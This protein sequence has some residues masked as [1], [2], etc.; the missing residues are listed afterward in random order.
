[1]TLAVCGLAIRSEVPLP[2]VP[3]TTDVPDVIIRL[4]RVEK[5]PG[6]RDA[7]R[8]YA[9]SSEEFRVFWRGVGTFSIRRGCEVIIDPDADTEEAILRLYILGPTLGI[10]LQQRGYLVLHAS[11][12]R[13]NGVAVGFL[14]EKGWG[15]ST[16]AA[17]LN[18]RG[19]S[20][21]ADDVLGIRMDANRRPMIKP[22]LP[23]FKLWPDSAVASFGD[24]PKTLSRLHSRVE[25][26][27]RVATTGLWATPQPL[28]YLYVLDRGA[29]LQSIPMSA[30]CGLMALVRHSYLSQH[31][32]ALGAVQDNFSQCVQ[33]CQQVVMS[34]LLRP[35]DL[36]A[37]GEVVSLIERE[38]G[39]NL[40]PATD[41]L[42]TTSGLCR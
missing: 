12:V 16:T 35:K 25:K 40:D 1:M 4:G 2:E 26:R 27:I 5:P 42:V 41:S 15:K 18:A 31:M 3:S 34:R 10:L 28:R 30:A 22:G 19:H 39:A 36:H 13:V 21:L 38:V 6:N 8:T 33:V 17:A 9:V 23:Q 14:G 37:L 29:E 7:E 32:M 24:D 11:A 20:L